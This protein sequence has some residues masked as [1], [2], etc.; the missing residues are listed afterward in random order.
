MYVA[1]NM[2]NKVYLVAVYMGSRS[3]EN[4]GGTIH[5]V[6]SIS[7]LCLYEAWT[8]FIPPRQGGIPLDADGIPTKAGQ[9]IPYKCFVTE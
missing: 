8:F 9:K 6:V 1:C 5:V 3:D 7:M 4:R 2:K